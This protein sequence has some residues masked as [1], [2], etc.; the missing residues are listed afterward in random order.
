MDSDILVR[1]NIDSL[2][3]LRAPA[4]LH[5]GVACG[6]AHGERINGRHFFGGTRPGFDANSQFWSSSAAGNFATVRGPWSWGQSGGINAGV[7]LF[8]P[9]LETLKLCLSEVTES[10]HPEHIPGSGPEQDYLSRF[11]AGEWSHINVAYN[12]QLHQMYFMVAWLDEGSHADRKEF[13]LRPELIKA[14]HYSADPKPWARLFSA[15]LSSLDDPAW[16]EEV[17]S[18]FSGYRAWIL[19]DPEYKYLDSY[20]EDDEPEVPKWAVEATDRVVALSLRES[21]RMPTG[22]WRACW[23]GPPSPRTSWRPTPPTAGPPRPPR[24]RSLR[25]RA[26]PRPAAAARG[27]RGRPRAG[28]AGGELGVGA[29]VG[30]A[31]RGAAGRGREPRLERGDD[32]WDHTTTWPLPHGILWDDMPAKVRSALETLGETRSSWDL[33]EARKVMP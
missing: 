9:D 22:T 18:K 2:F 10:S 3:Q 4:A 6:Y 1:E 25:S 8:E 33:W 5:R 14:F 13:L 17:K 23:A 29:A 28:R 32:S 19:K 30:A 16:A 24:P 31:A 15:S 21:G 27:S 7:M 26:A 12:F 20:G 11:Y